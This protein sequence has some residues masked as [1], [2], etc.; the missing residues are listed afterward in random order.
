MS[1]TARCVR[2]LRYGSPREALAVDTTALDKLRGHEVRVQLRAIAVNPLDC[3]ERR[4]YGS[5]LLGRFFKPLPCVLG[6]DGSGVVVE[7]GQD[8]WDYKVGDEVLVGIDPLRSGTY[9]Q[10]VKAREQEVAR[11]PSLLSHEDGACIPFATMT[12]WDALDKAGML[13]AHGRPKSVLVH[14]A[15]GAVGAAAT[16]LMATQGHR[17][18]TTSPEA[19]R[20]RLRAW[21]ARHALLAM[22]ATG[23]GKTLGSRGAIW[24][25]K[26][27]QPADPAGS[28]QEALAALGEDFDVLIDLVGGTE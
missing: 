14:G 23:S 28:L 5:E 22:P 16:Q 10:Y 17:V 26:D 27:A 11:K 6:R 19:A 25:A 20:E 4:G 21:G 7:V 18:V 3:S 13:D 1:G 8:V 12:A 24:E 2:L 9:C 15:G